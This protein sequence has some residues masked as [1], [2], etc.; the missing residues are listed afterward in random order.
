MTSAV[1]Y[2]EVEQVKFHTRLISESHRLLLSKRL[3]KL[4]ITTLT[5][6]W[7]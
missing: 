4:N 1:H 2:T 5:I 7:L 6:S 3:F